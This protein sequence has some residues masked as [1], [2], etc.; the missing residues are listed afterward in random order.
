MTTEEIEVIINSDLSSSQKS[1]LIEQLFTKKT[2]EV[3]ICKEGGKQELI[4]PHKEHVIDVMNGRKANFVQ[5]LKDPNRK[6][7]KNPDGSVS[8]HKLAWAEVDDKIIVY[9]EI[10]EINGELVD[11][12]N[13][14]EQA[15]KSA[16]ANNDYAEMQSPEEAEWFTTHYKEYYPN[17]NKYK[18]GGSA[19]EPDEEITIGDKK[20]SVSIADT[21]KE[22]RIGL[23]K[24][25]NLPKDEGML[26][27]FD[28]PV[29]Q[30]FTMAETDI[31]LDIV[32]ID[33]EGVVISVNSVKART[34]DPVVCEHEYKYVL[35]VNI[36]SGIEVGDELDQEDIDFTDEEKEQV[37]RSKML[38]LNSDGDVQM[39]LE[40]GER[41]VSMIK[42][43]QLIKAA[44]KAYKTDSDIDYRRVGRMIFKELDAQDG[45]D[46]QYVEK[47]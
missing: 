34:E 13:D 20:Y 27:V 43:R 32:F 45:R 5:R 2:E 44:L 40:G 4:L 46:P 41:I 6:V 47:N 37:K 28:E 3:P 33:E 7:I 15:L 39:K 19:P 16:L 17:F 23:S 18:D 35:E 30:Y 9:P 11:L 25:T 26:F 42:T 29:N 38:V 24:C 21:E 22:R 12:S 1:K 14:R 8:T 10:Q 31:D 36:N